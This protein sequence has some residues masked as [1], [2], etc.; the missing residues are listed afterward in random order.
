MEHGTHFGRLPSAKSAFGAR[1][2]E[3]IKKLLNL[4]STAVH[5]LYLCDVLPVDGV[6]VCHT[7]YVR[8]YIYASGYHM[9]RVRI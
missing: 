7:Q 8:G 3:S 2:Q 5:P 4:G 1:V 6:E 9:E